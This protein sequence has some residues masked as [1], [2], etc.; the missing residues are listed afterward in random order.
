MLL[1][2]NSNSAPRSEASSAARA[3]P[4]RYVRSRS[5]STRSSKSTAI[6]PGAGIGAE[7]ARIGVSIMRAYSTQGP[8]PGEPNLTHPMVPSRSTFLRGAG[9][10]GAVAIAP[11]IASPQ[12]PTSLRVITFSLA[13]DL[14]IW[15][16]I[17]KGFFAE[18]GLSIALTGTPNSAYMFEHLSANEFD[19]A[20]SSIDNAVAYDEGQ[21]PAVL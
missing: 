7:S 11:S 9:A 16:A 10:A 1:R 12:S 14:P 15:S 2:S 13:S 17:A 19:I 6:V 5:K 21:G 4:N 18:Q 3:R 20:H 8:G